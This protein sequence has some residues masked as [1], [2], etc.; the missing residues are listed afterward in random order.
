MAGAIGKVVVGR[1]ELLSLRTGR[2][3]MSSRWER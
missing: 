1:Y 3:R 2:R